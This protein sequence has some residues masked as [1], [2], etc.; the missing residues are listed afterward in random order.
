MKQTLLTIAIALFIFSC[1]PKNDDKGFIVNETAKAR[2]DSTLKSIVD[3]GS[4]AGVSHWF[5]K[6][7]RKF[8]L[9]LLDIP[10]AKPK[11]RW[12]ATRSVRIFP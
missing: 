10:I 1:K 2:I 7:I 3:G 11:C 9:T 4:I 5:L 8:T 6:K 12:I